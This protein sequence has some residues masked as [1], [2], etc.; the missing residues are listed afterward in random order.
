M[1]ARAGKPC[2]SRGCPQLRP[3]PDHPVE[4][5]AGSTRRRRI[6]KS[7][8]RQ[9]RDAA[10]VMRQHAGICHVCGRPGA[11]EVD[12]VIPVSPYFGGTDDDRNKR[13]IHSR[14]CHA[15]KTAAEATQAR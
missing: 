9:Q 14:P 2:Q 13:P 8:S 4:A 11:D 3:C 12:H 5:W 7:G 1:T 10:R 15:T 6:G